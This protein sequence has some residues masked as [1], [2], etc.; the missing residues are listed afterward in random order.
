M[1]YEELVVK[2]IVKEKEGVVIAKFDGETPIHLSLFNFL[3]KHINGSIMNFYNLY[4]LDPFIKIDD[5]SGV[6]KTNFEHDTFNVEYG[7]KLARK[8]LYLKLWNRIYA[9]NLENSRMINLLNENYKDI[10]K[11]IDKIRNT[12]KLNCEVFTSLDPNNFKKIER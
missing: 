4:E 10:V 11:K 9:E 1:D 5:L 6:A 8:K 12:R 3:K 2:Y 7:K